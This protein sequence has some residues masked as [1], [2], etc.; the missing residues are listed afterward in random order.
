MRAVDPTPPPGSAGKRDDGI[1]VAEVSLA[2]TEEEN[3]KATAVI[4]GSG[5]K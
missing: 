2:L 5:K 4:G 3:G 1:I